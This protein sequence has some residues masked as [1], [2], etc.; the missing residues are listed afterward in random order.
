MTE[1][2]DPLKSPCDDAAVFGKLPQFTQR[3]AFYGRVY[4]LR[5]QRFRYAPNL[6]R[7]WLALLPG[8]LVEE[9]RR[10]SNG[11]GLPR[12]LTVAELVGHD[13]PVVCGCSPPSADDSAEVEGVS[14]A[15]VASTEPASP[16]RLLK[17]P[18]VADV[19]ERVPAIKANSRERSVADETLHLRREKIQ[20][21]LPG[22]DIGSRRHPEGGVEIFQSGKIQEIH[23]P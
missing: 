7:E 3:M 18:G 5:H 23:A 20:G 6:V 11:E 10:L 14:S 17:P 2:L 19:A 16:Q 1:P 12:H 22:E 15:D 4:C 8:V 13:G 9:R 21:L